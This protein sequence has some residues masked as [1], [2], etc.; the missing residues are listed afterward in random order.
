MFQSS[1]AAV[2]PAVWITAVALGGAALIFVPM[3]IFVVIMNKHRLR[4]KEIKRAQKLEGERLKTELEITKKR[5]DM[6]IDID[7][8]AKSPR[9]CRYC[10][11]RNAPGAQTCANCGS[12]M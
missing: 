12:A 5:A 6:E 7:R 10:G 1:L 11:T 2:E 4:D 3:M 9:F 8:E